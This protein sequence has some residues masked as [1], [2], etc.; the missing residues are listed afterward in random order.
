MLGVFVAAFAVA[1][2][3]LIVMERGGTRLHG[4][5]TYSDMSAAERET[6]DARTDEWAR[7]LGAK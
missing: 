1:L 5:R 4:E 2:V 7:Y 3:V 6:F